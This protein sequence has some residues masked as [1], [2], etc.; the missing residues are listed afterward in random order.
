L[1]KHPKEVS[2]FL[3]NYGKGKKMTH[4]KELASFD[5]K[6]GEKKIIH[7]TRSG[8]R[9]KNNSSTVV[10]ELN[11]KVAE[12]TAIK[13]KTRRLELNLSL[14]ELCSKAGIASAT[15]KS[16]MWEIENNS[17][18]HG[19]RFGTLYALAIALETTPQNL[20]PTVE[21]VMRGA[22]IDSVNEKTLRVKP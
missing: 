2:E 14:E 20:M 22:K 6:Y 18:K 1:R 10:L 11:K 15:P 9:V 12:L 17:A 8:L 3:N 13:I 21:D 7:I 4:G 19:L 16:R 5:N